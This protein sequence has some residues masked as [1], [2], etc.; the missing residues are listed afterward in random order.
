MELVIATR[1]LAT[2][3]APTPTAVKMAPVM[4]NALEGRGATVS[5]HQ[6]QCDLPRTRCLTAPGLCV[7]Q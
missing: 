4:W 1:K 2:N 3:P 6:Y 7:D 5:L